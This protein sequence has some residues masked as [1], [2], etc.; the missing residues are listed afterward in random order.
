M[1]IVHSG[2]VCIHKIKMENND[3]KKK[4]SRRDAL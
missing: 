2:S 3:Y 1:M 4:E